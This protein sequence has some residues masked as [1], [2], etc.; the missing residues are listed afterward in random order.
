MVGLHCASGACRAASLWGWQRRSKRQQ[1]SAGECRLKHAVRSW[2][3]SER[4][5]G[6]RWKSEKESQAEALVG[7]VSRRQIQR[8]WKKV[9]ASAAILGCLKR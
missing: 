8:E 2:K 5:R 9:E 4:L 6:M 1:P 7:T 3:R